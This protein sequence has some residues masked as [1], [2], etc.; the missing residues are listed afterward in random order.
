MA[1]LLFQEGV[2]LSV[3]LVIFNDHNTEHKMTRVHT[4]REALGDA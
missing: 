3:S 4:Q 1:V 2:Q